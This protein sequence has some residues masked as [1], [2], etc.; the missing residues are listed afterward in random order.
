[1]HSKRVPFIFIK[2]LAMVYKKFSVFLAIMHSRRPKKEFP[3]RGRYISDK[4]A[5]LHA[6]N[7]LAFH[8]PF[9]FKSRITPKNPPTGA[10][11]TVRNNKT[12]FV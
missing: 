4:I 1:M 9:S 7:Q 12:Q 6:A 8:H 2:M 5:A 11:K 10:C 3:S